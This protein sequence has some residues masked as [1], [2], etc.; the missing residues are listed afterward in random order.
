M[1]R[2]RIRCRPLTDIPVTPWRALA[3]RAIEANGYYQPD[4]ELAVDASRVAA[5]TL[6]RSAPSTTR[7][8]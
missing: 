5:L 7:A 8:S 2:P 3:E 6:P 4:W 1:P